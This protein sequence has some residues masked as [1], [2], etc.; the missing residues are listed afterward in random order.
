M[1]IN[2]CDLSHF[3]RITIFILLFNCVASSFVNYSNPITDPCVGHKNGRARVITLDSTIGSCSEYFECFNGM[4]TT[5]VPFSCD[6][7]RPY[8]DAESQ[9]CVEIFD[10]CFQCPY[11]IDYKLLTVPHAPIQFIQCF[12]RR[13]LLLACSENLE[14]DERIQQCNA[15]RLCRDKNLTG[16]RCERG[17]PHYEIDVLEPSV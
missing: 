2:K 4:K 1:A 17:G 15:K 6:S 14:F 16:R 7:Y 5:D 13:P 10:V 11:D 9:N 3:S 8:F 12:Q